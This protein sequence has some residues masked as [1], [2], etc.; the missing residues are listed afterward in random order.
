M[1]KHN[2]VWEKPTN[3]TQYVGQETV[4]EVVNVLADSANKEKRNLQNILLSGE[5]GLGKSTLGKLIFEKYK[6]PYR[7]HNGA[8]LSLVKHLLLDK[9]I[10]F[11]GHYLI[12]E[13]HN[14]PPQITDLMHSSMDSGD[15]SIIGMTTNPGKLTG[16]FRSRFYLL[17]LQ[18]YSIEELSTIIDNATKRR[19]SFL[20]QK[21]VSQEVAKR[22]RQTAR[23]AI[24]NISFMFDL[25]TTKNT[26]TITL[27]LIKEG[28][29]KLRIDENGLT[30]IDHKYLNSLPDDR[31]VGVQYISAKIGVDIETIEEEI[32]PFLMREGLI[33]RSNKGRYKLST[34]LMNNDPFNQLFEMAKS[35]NIEVEK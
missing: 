6:T 20:L 24:Q 28:F 33:D 16:P 25:A 2:T 15:C 31:P 21:D 1:T 8:S 17:T 14:I 35:M 34:I 19:G 27:D 26:K 32:E 11:K 7:E 3:F 13:I 18:P 30:E 4:K 23:T 10:A 22:S 5:Y 9:K 12:D 29:E